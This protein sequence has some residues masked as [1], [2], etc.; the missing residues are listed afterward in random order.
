MN[1]AQ[2][3]CPLVEASEICRVRPPECSML[4]SDRWILSCRRNTL[5]FRGTVS[6]NRR[7]SRTW[8]GSGILKDFLT[9]FQ[10]RPKAERW[11]TFTITCV[12]VILIG[13]KML[14]PSS[15]TCATD[16]RPSTHNAVKAKSCCTISCSGIRPAPFTFQHFR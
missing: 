16:S 9:K 8:P 12:S 10:I 4:T 5:I 1:K 7:N 11:E 3:V 13:F 14:I 6:L 2:G 15:K